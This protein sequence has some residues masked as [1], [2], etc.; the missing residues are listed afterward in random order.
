MIT[1][2]ST[3]AKKYSNKTQEE[4]PKV[5]TVNDVK[6]ERLDYL[7]KVNKN[8]KKVDEAVAKVNDEFKVK[9][10]YSIPVDTIKKYIDK[11]KAEEGKNPLEFWSAA[12]ISEEMVKYI[13][14]EYL[15]ID[16][17]PSSL[18]FGENKTRDEEE[19]DVEETNVDV[20]ETEG[21]G[22]SEQTEEDFNEDTEEE[23]EVEEEEENSIFG[24]SDS[25]TDNDLK[26]LQ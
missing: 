2:F 21:E 20:E 8:V 13:L 17:I 15:T 11:V 7:R 14:D 10:V 5:K 16:N 24:M 23:V 25:F 4:Q 22:E 19:K 12:D 18:V 1:K 3:F 26:I 9:T 6:K